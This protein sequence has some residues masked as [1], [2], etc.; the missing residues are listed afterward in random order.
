MCDPIKMN[1]M[2]ILEKQNMISAVKSSRDL[3]LGEMQIFKLKLLT[4]INVQVLNPPT[5]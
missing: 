2:D 1:P 3:K 5:R 4:N